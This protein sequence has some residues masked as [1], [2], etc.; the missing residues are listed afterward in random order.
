MR[1]HELKT[2][3]DVFQAT[4][5][6]KKTAEFRKNDRDFQVGDILH[7]REYDPIAQA[8]LQRVIRAT[9]IHIVYGGSYGIPKGYC[10]MSITLPCI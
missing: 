10:L 8:Y 5:D 1:I 9:V 2:W 3:P 6:G 7:L 4:W